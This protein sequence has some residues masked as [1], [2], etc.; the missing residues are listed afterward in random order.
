MAAYDARPWLARY[1]P[2]QPAEIAPEHD[3]ALAMF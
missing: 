3:S 2:G 1:A